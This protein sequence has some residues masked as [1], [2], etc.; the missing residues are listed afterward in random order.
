MRKASDAVLRIPLPPPPPLRLD[1]EE[2]ADIEAPPTPSAG[3]LNEAAWIAANVRIPLEPYR[4]PDS[5]YAVGSA[6]PE[7]RETLVLRV[8]SV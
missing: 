4:G 6:P 7:E 8:P 5:P 3:P 1:S 2:L